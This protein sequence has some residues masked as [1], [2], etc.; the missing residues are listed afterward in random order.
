MRRALSPVSY[1]ILSNPGNEL[2]KEMLVLYPFKEE[3]TGLGH[4]I[5]LFQDPGLIRH[6]A[7]TCTSVFPALPPC[8]YFGPVPC[9]PV[10]DW[11]LFIQPASVQPLAPT[12]HLAAQ[13]L[14][15]VNAGQGLQDSGVTGASQEPMI[16]P[17]AKV[18]KMSGRQGAGRVEG[19]P[20]WTVC[21][22]P[23]RPAC[24]CP[25]INHCLTLHF[26]P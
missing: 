7:G 6:G 26:L 18:G 4:L 19:V 25:Q 13:W 20:L 2:V 10:F 3:E 15:S 14:D 21:S 23:L 5:D 11:G 8:P 1:I 9:C 24:N 16:S 22:L 12:R 17:T